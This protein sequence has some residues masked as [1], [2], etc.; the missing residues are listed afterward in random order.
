MCS[1][2]GGAGS[3]LRSAAIPD[4]VVA[5]R[6]KVAGE[7]SGSRRCAW[8]TISVYTARTLVRSK[9]SVVFGTGP[10]FIFIF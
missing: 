3:G 9:R 5:R 6:T 1:G 2:G 10:Y 7:T 8:Q 4:D